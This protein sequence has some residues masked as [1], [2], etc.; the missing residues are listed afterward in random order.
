MFKIKC[1]K[2]SYLGF[3]VQYCSSYTK[4]CNKEVKNTNIKRHEK[5]K[6]DSRK[7]NKE[8]GH[9]QNNQKTI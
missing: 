8:Q 6:R 7:R 5:T 2:L 4:Y 9:L 1:Y 3:K